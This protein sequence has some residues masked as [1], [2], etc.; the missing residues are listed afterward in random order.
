MDAKATKIDLLA[1]D[2]TDQLAAL[3]SGCVTAVELLGAS[4]E[5]VERLDARINAVVTRDVDRAMAEA[6]ASDAARARGEA[7][8]PL[9]GLPMTVKCVLDIEGLPA[10]AGMK[11]LLARKA[12]DSEVV[13]RLRAAGA[14][15]WGHTNVPVGSAD[16]QT[17]NPLYGTT[18]NPWDLERTPGGSSGGSAA[19]LAAGFTALEIG[20]DISGS[21]R[22]PASFCGV[23]AHRPSWGL[24]SQCGLVPPADRAADLDMAV[25]GPMA[26]SVRDLQLL[27]SV[28]ASLPPVEAPDMGALR[29]RVWADEPG[30]PLDPEVEAIVREAA[31]LLGAKGAVVAAEPSPLPVRPMMSAYMT[32]LMALLGSTW[33]PA[34]RGLFEALRGPARLAVAAGAGPLSWAHGV[35][36]VSARHREWLAADEA[37]ARLKQS[38]ARVFENC[39]LILAPVTPTAAFRHDHGP[40]L[41]ARRIVASDGRRLPYLETFDWIALATLCDLPSTVVPAGRTGEGLPIGVQLIGAPRKDAATL[42]AAGA[43]EAVLGGFV[44]PPMDWTHS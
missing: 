36:A 11:A 27:M 23:C 18:R 22:I 17:Y 13:S 7:P 21:L 42:A 1:S 2:A 20:A 41:A 3:R 34:V 5:R 29:V 40:L 39:D 24:V 19:A 14:I 15:V 28:I 35:L 6:R 44:P 10:S 30:F 43:V 31:Q 25:V 16:W 9:A 37:R 26:R 38:V 32:L 33:P 8:G 12:V 4:L